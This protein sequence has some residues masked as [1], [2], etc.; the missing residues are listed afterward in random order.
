MT[1]RSGRCFVLFLLSSFVLAIESFG[2]HTRGEVYL[3][4]CKRR[5]CGKV[6]QQH[7][8]SIVCCLIHQQIHASI[9]NEEQNGRRIHKFAFVA[10]PPIF[11]HLPPSWLSTRTFRSCDSTP[12]AW[13][14]PCII[15]GQRETCQTFTL[16]C[17]GRPK[18][19]QGRDIGEIEDD[20]CVTREVLQETWR[21]FRL[22]KW[23][24]FHFLR[25]RVYRNTLEVKVSL[26]KYQKTPN[27]G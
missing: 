25:T 20:S 24:C 22:L 8:T 19:R 2:T 17:F 14:L 15:S 18:R 4:E 11:N 23:S 13:H 1:C 3:K 9:I 10:N 27:F 26:L 12:N 5:N 16:Q 21:R 6:H 7:Y